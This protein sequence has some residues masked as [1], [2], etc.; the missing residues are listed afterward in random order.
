MADDIR[1]SRRNLLRAGGVSLTGAALA[2]VNVAH[3]AGTPGPTVPADTGA[4]QGGR[5]QFPNWRG[6][7]D[8][9]PAPT[10]APQPPAK[11][12]GYCV[13]GLGRLASTRSC[14]PSAKPS[15]RA[16]WR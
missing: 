2:G 8:R 6:E 3:G 11:R 12:V 4:V 16:S 15:A 7:G 5:I 1:V 9:P 13:V 14:R 10:P